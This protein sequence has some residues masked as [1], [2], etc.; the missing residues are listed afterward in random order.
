V[1]RALLK[2]MEETDVELRVAHDMVSQ[3]EAL[4]DWRR[5]GKREKKT[6]NTRNILFILSG[7]FTG[8]D[9]IVKR[10]LTSSDIGFRAAEKAPTDAPPSWYLHQAVPET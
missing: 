3:M 4:E 8:L 10:R 2:P 5:T 9:E 6:V 7:A 1:Q